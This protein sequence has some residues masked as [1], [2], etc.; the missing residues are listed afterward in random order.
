MD[1]LV[2][3]RKWR[4]QVFEDVIGQD[5]IVKTL[6]NAIR[7]DRIAHAYIF[8]GPRGIGKTSVARIMAKALNCEN[9]PAETPCNRCINCREITEG[10]S[11]DVRE[12]DGAS[13]RGIDEVREL[14]E[15]IKFSP[16]SSP[17]KIY[18]IDEVHMLTKEAFNALLKTVEEPPPHVIFIFAT[19]EI[20]KVPATILSRCQRHDF[21][22]VPL[23]QIKDHLRRIA[24]SEGIEVGDVGLGWIAESAEGS[25]R[26]AQSIFDQVISYA[27]SSIKDGDIEVLLGLS[28]RRLLFDL[29]AAVLNR[30]GKSCLRIIDEAYY[31]GLDMKHFYQK[32]LQHFLNLLLMKIAGPERGLFDLPETDITRL[33]EQAGG[34]SRDTLQ[35]LVDILM[36][37]D[38][39]V[40]K[41]LS[42]K[43]NIE[44]VLVKMTYL[45]P[46]IPID[47]I[48]TR[49]ESLERRLSA[50]GPEDGQA[51]EGA[52]AEA[53]KT[54]RAPAQESGPER[55][56]DDYR[57]LVKKK[58][59]PLW[60]KIEAGKFL[61]FEKGCL[62]IGFPEDH[63]LLDT[64]NEKSQKDRL[65]EI[66]RE[67]LGPDTAIKIVSSGPP[68]ENGLAVQNGIGQ[69]SRK[70]NNPRR[71]ALNHPL[72][73]KVLDV[74]EG[75]EI[76]EVIVKKSNESS[77]LK[78]K[79]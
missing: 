21:R 31:A 40:R 9:G 39:E 43:L 23:R 61:G 27:G 51:V 42:P 30:D 54:G 53:E 14:R 11:M 44:F 66:A 77:G 58:S 79:D 15:N 59:I 22:R 20:H 75:A 17:F 78:T 36:A 3:A 72:V 34:V 60:S 48:L 12:I 24:V 65:T 4:P 19:T 64:L 37:E 55:I 41:S 71:E 74:F 70:N 18:I 32:L 45:E 47:E 49:M 57:N 73:Q 8:S 7:Y 69:N 16:A 1:Y 46:R 6:K 26:D 33:Q 25:M 2:L 56:W 29:S 28:D 5:H 76:K 67:L 10:I 62:R 63:I 50:S 52:Y 13:N 38:E 35:R 68:G